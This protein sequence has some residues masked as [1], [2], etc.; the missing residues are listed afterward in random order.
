MEQVSLNILLV[1]DN[2]GDAR[3]LVEILK[4]E[5]TFSAELHHAERLRDALAIL[6]K[7]KIDIILLDLSLPDSFGF[8][9]FS[10]MHEH[11]Q[12]VPI[13]LLT[14]TDDETLAVKA[15]KQGAQDYLFK[16]Q[17]DSSLLVRSIKYA[18]ERQHLL[19]EMEKAREL[20]QHL[21]YHDVLTSL[22]NRLLFY[23]RLQ[24]ALAHAKRYSGLLAIMFIDLDGFKQINDSKGHAVGDKLLQNVAMRLKQL[25]RE[26]DTIGRLGG[27][28]FTIL[29]K[30][31]KSAQNIIKVAEKVLHGLAKP[32]VFDGHT[33][34]LTASI[35]VSI[36]PH[37]GEDIE[38]LIKKADYAMYRAKSSGKNNF[39]LFNL[40]MESSGSSRVSLENGLQKA[41][42]N[43]ELMVFYQPQVDIKTGVITGL[44]ALVRWQHPKHGLISPADFIPMAE[45]SGLIVPL[46][47]W[48]LR[49][50]CQQNKYWQSAGYPAVPIA[51]NLS[52]RQ[53]RE[54]SLAKT[55]ADVLHESDLEAEYLMLEITESNAMQDV[56][57]T[58]STLEVLKEMGVQIA[59][60]DFGTGYSSLSYLKRFPIDMLKIDKS[61][62]LDIPQNPDDAS[63]IAA[64]V[65]LAHSLGMKV[66][67]EGVETKEQLNFLRSINCDQIQG[68][69]FSPPLQIDRLQQLLDS[70]Q[71]LERIEYRSTEVKVV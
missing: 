67:A 7:E 29:L 9:T 22:P 63:I 8:E 62:V 23:D 1:E 54:L 21:A 12:G 11:A 37:D 2:P 60:D 66:I 34:P 35:G 32:Y 28:E 3:L 26:S 61:F 10:C 49:V 46:G 15:L 42:L 31:V 56:E 38:T 5:N 36:Y 14:G 18:I 58:V 6:K 50:A 19:L 25:M 40:A 57:Y 27:D 68:F 59:V 51:I 64:I 52:A 17:V 55:V 69:Y 44:E 43:D 24:Q 30:G 53:F 45:E 65:A 33:L 39:Q 41:I 70:G 4:E 47:Q 16:G 13:V 71:R 20:E 48:V